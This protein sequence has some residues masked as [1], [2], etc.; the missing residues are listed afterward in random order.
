MGSGRMSLA[1]ELFWDVDNA[2]LGKHEFARH[3]L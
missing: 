3:M 2:F 1:K